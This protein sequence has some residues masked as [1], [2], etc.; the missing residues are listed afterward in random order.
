LAIGLLDQA[1][2]AQVIWKASAGFLRI[3]PRKG[4]TEVKENQREAGT[5]RETHTETKKNRQREKR[6]EG[7]QK[8]YTKYLSLAIPD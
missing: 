2:L 8:N 6:K 3:L 5:H 7:I 4:G 1:R